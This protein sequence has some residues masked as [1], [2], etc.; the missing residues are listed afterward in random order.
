MG[1]YESVHGGVMGD[2][3]AD[4]IDEMA[5]ATDERIKWDTPA[6]I[7]SDV[8]AEIT[9]LYREGLGREPMVDDLKAVVGYA[10]SN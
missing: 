1:W 10:A 7:P 4:L 2:P 9:E 8:R 5:E 6:D 3:A